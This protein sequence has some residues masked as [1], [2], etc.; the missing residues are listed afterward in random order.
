[1]PTTRSEP[2][3]KGLAVVLLL[4]VGGL[5]SARAA[6]NTDW[7]KKALE[8]NA[9]TGNDTSSGQILTYLEDQASGKKVLAAAAELIKDKKKQP[10]NSN[11]TFILARLAHAFKQPALSQELFQIHIEQV[12]KLGS[13]DRLGLAYAS[14]IQMFFDNNKF[15]E[16]EKAARTFLEMEGDDGLDRFKPRTERLLIMAMVKRGQG[17]EAVKLLDRMIKRAPD[18]WITLELK[19]RVLR[20]L[21][22]VEDA[23]KIYE[24]MIERI[25]KDERLTKDIREEFVADHRYALSTLYVELNKIDKAA[26]QLKALLVKEPDNPTYNNDLGFIWADHGMNLEESEKL[27]R[28]ALEDDRKQRTKSNPEVK[29]AD[30]KDNPAYLDSMGWVLFKQK[31]YKEA[32]PYLLKAVEQELGQHCEIFDHLADCHMAL[33]EKT[34][35]IATWKKAVEVASSSAREQKR[36]AIIE[37]KLKEHE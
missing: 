2:G 16:A 30:Y 5:V 1:M 21:T 33:G 12:K 10:L 20:E 23:A 36:K 4:C 6:D 14:L 9:V 19:A 26:E 35:A 18:N 17:E 11:A 31:K 37:K 7:K 24:D 3:R 29:P 32:K 8:L 25:P 15:D 34:E 22:R 13:E 27:I 28:K